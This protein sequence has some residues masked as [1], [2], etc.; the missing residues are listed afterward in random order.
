MGAD[1]FDREGLRIRVSLERGVN[2]NSMLTFLRITMGSQDPEI[3]SAAREVQA[4][5]A[6]DPKT[7]LAEAMEAGVARRVDAELATGMMAGMMETLAWRG[8]RDN[9]YDAATIIAFLQDMHARTLSIHSHEDERRAQVDA[10]LRGSEDVEWIIKATLPSSWAEDG[11]D[12]T[13]QKL[14]DAAVDLL[15]G[16]GYDSL[17]VDDI[18][19]LA[20]VAK[21]T[22]YHHFTSK[23]DVLAAV[24]R[25]VTKNMQYVGARIDAADLDY[26]AKVALRMRVALE[27]RMQWHRTV[28]FVRIMSNQAASEVGACAWEVFRCL[29]DVQKRDFEQAMRRGLVRRLDPELAATAVLG[30]E[31]ILAWRVKQDNTYD[32]AAVVAFMADIY[33][34]AFLAN[35]LMD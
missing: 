11:T 4:H 14:V 29:A 30:M 34:R 13:R 3:V 27:P 9:S 24:F 8:R 19:D 32:P 31:E 17:R 20:G 26:L 18:T 15:N 10:M 16:A 33:C 35:P 1:Y 28:T 21:G 2:W 23:Q 7:Y 12:D 22:F 25:R 6:H 5:M